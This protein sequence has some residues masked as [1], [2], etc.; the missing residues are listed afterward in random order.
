MVCLSLSSHAGWPAKLGAWKGSRQAGRHS[1][2]RLAQG[3]HAAVAAAC[4]SS[5]PGQPPR[6]QVRAVEQ[7]NCGRARQRGGAVCL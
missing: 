6:P 2:G 7:G 4:P 1:A 3:T 5:Q